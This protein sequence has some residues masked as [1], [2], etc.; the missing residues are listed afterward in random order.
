MVLIT[1]EPLIEEEIK[2]LYL[3]LKAIQVSDQPL[4]LSFIHDYLDFLKI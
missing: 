1:K 4:C 3:D 2:N